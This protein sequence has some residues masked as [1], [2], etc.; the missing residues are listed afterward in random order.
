MR[1][2]LQG[3]A[4]KYLGWVTTDE[5]LGS[6]FRNFC[7]GKRDLYFHKFIPLPGIY[8]YSV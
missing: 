1:V 4:S 8:Y 2:N 7:I 3:I 6:I 5:I